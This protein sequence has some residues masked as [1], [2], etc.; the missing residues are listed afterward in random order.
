MSLDTLLDR[1]AIVVIGSANSS[2][3]RALEKLAQEAGCSAVYRVNSVDELYRLGL[4]FNW[5]PVQ[6]GFTQGWRYFRWQQVNTLAPGAGDGNVTQPILGQD[7]HA[8]AIASVEENKV[9]TPVTNAW[10]TGK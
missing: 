6:G 8:D 2:N 9:N 10:M 7:V 1:D 3:A 4:G 5:G